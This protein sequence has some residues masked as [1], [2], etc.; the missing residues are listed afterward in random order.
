MTLY[1]GDGLSQFLILN[2]QPDHPGKFVVQERR[3]SAFDGSPVTVTLAVVDT[4]EAAR[5]AIRETDCMICLPP[6]P[7]DPSGAI[8]SWV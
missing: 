7:E 6:A 3:S 1:K 4:L 8:E 5:D 2:N